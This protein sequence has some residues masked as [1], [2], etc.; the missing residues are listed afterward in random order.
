VGEEERINGLVSLKNMQTKQQEKIS[1]EN[2]VQ[3]LNAIK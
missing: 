2:L 3:Q 1:F